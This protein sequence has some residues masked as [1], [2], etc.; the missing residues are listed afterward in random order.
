MKNTLFL[1]GAVGLRILGVAVYKTGARGIAS[2]A[3]GVVGDLSQGVLNA[4]LNVP[5]TDAQKCS[6]AKAECDWWGVS[7]FCPVGDFLSYSFSSCDPKKPFTEL[8]ES[9]QG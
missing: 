7:K 4:T 6:K 8:D 5:Y 3:V 9:K 1:I 2:G